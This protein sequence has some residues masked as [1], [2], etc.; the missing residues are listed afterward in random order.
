MKRIP[1]WKRIMI[2][3]ILLVMVL[4][5]P[6]LAGT[7]TPDDVSNANPGFIAA[8][9]DAGS[10]SETPA[11]TG[12]ADT[13]WPKSG[14]DLNN[15]GQSPYV[16]SQTGTVK[17]TFPTGKEG[18]YTSS[19]IGSDGTIYISFNNPQRSDFAGINAWDQNGTL[20][21]NYGKPWAKGISTPAIGAD[22]TIYMNDYNSHC[23]IAVSPNGT[24]K[25]RQGI[26]SSAGSPAI[27]SD[28]S[29]YISGPKLFYAFTQDGEPKW[30]YS[31]A[32]S[33]RFSRFTSPAIG[34]DGT[35]YCTNEGGI[36]AL[37]PDTGHEKWYY[38]TETIY[39]SPAI[40]VDGNI[41]AGSSDGNLYVLNLNGTWKGTYS[42][43][44][45]LV[46]YGSPAIGSD[47][48][49]Y[50]G[51]SNKK[52]YALSPD[53]T[54]KWNYSTGGSICASPAI[55]GDGTIY[56]GSSDG[57]IYALDSGGTPKWNYSIGNT[58]L[59]QP[60]IDSDGTVYIGSVGK[61]GKVYAFA[62][63]SDF[64]SGKQTG[65]APFT[66]QFT[67]TSTLSSTSLLWDF[68][69]GSS[70]NATEQNPV[71][72]YT[73]PGSYTVNLTKIYGSGMN[74]VVKYNYINVYS[75]PVANFTSNVT[76][77]STPFT[78]QF[79]DT[80]TGTPTNW[81]WDFGDGTNSTDQNPT[82]TYTTTGTSTGT[83]TVNLT[84]TNAAG[85]NTTSRADYI[86]VSSAAPVVSF[87][88]TPRTSGAVPLTVRFNDTSTL[89]PTSWL[90]DFGDGTNSTE[91]HPTHTYT[92]A[93]TYTV[94]LTGTNVIGS[95]TA[96]KPG[97]ITC[98]TPGP[99][100]YNGASIYVANDAGVKHDINGT[101]VE[102]TPN[103]YDF[104]FGPGGLNALSIHDLER[105]G[106]IHTT[107]QS[108]TIE[109]RF[110]GGQPTMHNGVLML[111]VNG[112]IPDDFSV[113]IKA[114]GDT[115]TLGE[116]GTSNLLAPT[117]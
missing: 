89:H 83:F 3:A 101:H 19:L 38:P 72:T 115:W 16:G 7:V 90:W 104:S 13:P 110:G 70:E 11:A 67:D 112:T 31:D 10:G 86:T 100:P 63:P 61:G 53:G 2:S 111:A 45:D 68:G 109:V 48:T 97:Y 91:Q 96:S 51:S 4:A 17:G 66:V 105:N 42:I 5:A 73:S 116:P 20:K 56:I 92:S 93:G 113:H 40:G 85:S 88:G 117:D 25:W 74:Q 58:G 77:G 1:L 15:T 36:F 27:G 23:L 26:S 21:W 55:G 28:G 14:Y 6:A 29:I 64:T 47:G 69:D 84:A 82:H 76:S 108:G 60:S 50:I 54:P 43:G 24:C 75:A 106:I 99:I 52:L 8:A 22:G 33:N 32:N 81:F 71:H 37:D 107:N 18:G 46:H 94:T 49:I 12:L 65:V 39:G 103:T 9:D 79:T 59:C 57:K 34:P 78:V 41:Y 35:V 44:G 102:H 62:G 87:T 114:S 30:T 98:V 80:S 95:S